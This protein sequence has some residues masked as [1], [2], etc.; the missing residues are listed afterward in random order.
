MSPTRRRLFAGLVAAALGSC[1]AGDPP[2][3]PPP[4]SLTF[5]ADE[6]IPP[7]THFDG[8]GDDLFGGLSAVAYVSGAW[9]ALSDAR[10]RPRLFRLDVELTPGR[11]RVSPDAVFFLADPSGKGFAENVLD[12]EGLARTPWG[13]WLVSTEP[14]M[15][16]DP[17]EP[18]KILELD[19]EGRFL[20]A[21]EVPEEYLTDGHPPRRG[22]R[23]NLGF[24]AL[25]FAPDGASLFVGAE[26]TLTQDGP[27]AS[28]DGPGSSRILRYDVSGRA[29]VPKA[30]L[31]YPLGP[32]A[33]ERGFKTAMVYGGLVELVVLG[34]NRMLALERIFIQ[35]VEGEGRNVTRARIYEVDTSEATDV[36]GVASLG[37]TLDWRPVSKRLLLDLDDVRGE[38]SPGYQDLDNFEAMG[39][40]PPLEDGGRELLLA[41][42]DNFGASQRS[43]F[44]LFRLE[45]CDP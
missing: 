17:P 9:Y 30:E 2:P 32:Y 24:E 1:A 22:L 20:R 40:G 21:I 8:A 4:L 34:P 36:R 23:H 42:D 28:F 15:R 39:L 25:A 12:P 43:Q 31:V 26:E 27:A 45:G 5:I 44:L 13:T 16:D 10:E 37:K 18:A 3:A 33:K 29:L 11:M 41:S 38:L 6:N 35:E 7:G 19:D 14:D